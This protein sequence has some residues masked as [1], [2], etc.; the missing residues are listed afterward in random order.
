METLF[1]THL[2]LDAYACSEEA[3]ADEGRIEQL[4][5]ELPDL[6]AM[7]RIIEPVVLEVGPNNKKDPGGISGFVMIAESHISV[8]TFPKRGFLTADVYTC[9]GDL[10]TETVLQYFKNIFST[11][12]IEHTVVKRG[13]RY[14][15]TDIYS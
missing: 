6:L 9:Q 14:P 3:L 5:I 1:G 13:T 4:L 2:L 10:D 15:E 11:T 12:D 7:T 8:H